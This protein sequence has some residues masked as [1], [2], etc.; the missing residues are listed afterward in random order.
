M[1]TTKA[2]ENIKIIRKKKL[3]QK[4]KSKREKKFYLIK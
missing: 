2:A 3:Q 1:Q 4:H